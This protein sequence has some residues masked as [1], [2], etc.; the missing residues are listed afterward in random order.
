MDNQHSLTRRFH[1][2]DLTVPADALFAAWLEKTMGTAPSVL[3]DVPLIGAP[4]PGEGGINGGLARDEV[5]KPYWL[6][7]PPAHV[8]SFEG[9]EW[10]GQGFEEPDAKSEFD[11]LA[12][13]IALCDSSHDHAAARRCHG[14][15][16]DGLNDFYLPAKREAAV[17]FANVREEFEKAWY[18]TSTQYSADYAWGQYFGDGYQGHATKDFTGRVRAVRRLDF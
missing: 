18:F 10:G 17:L 6:I 12:N 1:G 14:I 13:T 8:S 15:V 2:A 4:W 5:G 9:I 11:G 7:L 16:Y 3:R